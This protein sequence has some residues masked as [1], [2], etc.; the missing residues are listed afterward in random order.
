MSS[1]QDVLIAREKAVQQYESARH[2]LQITF[3]LVK[4]PKLLMGVIHNI[5]A[6]LEYSMNAILAY[7][8]ILRLVPIY[9]PEFRSRFNLFRLKSVKRNNIPPETINLINELR[10][11]LDLHKKS[12]IGFQRGN[13]FVIC[14]KDYE[15]KVI[16]IKEIQTYLD[17]TKEMLQIMQTITGKHF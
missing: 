12:P 11:V 15:L 3:P 2:L 16:S 7:E 8:R 17:K 14:N 13:K 5:S 10:Q 9:G 6:S 4:D 1:Q